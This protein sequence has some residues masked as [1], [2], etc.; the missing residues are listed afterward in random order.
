MSIGGH[1][2]SAMAAPGRLWILDPP[3]GERPVERIALGGDYLPALLAGADDAGRCAAMAA[4]LAPAVEGAGWMMADEHPEIHVEAPDPLR[5]AA[6]TLHLTVA[7]VDAL[8][9][10]VVAGG[11]TLDRGPEEG[12]VGR[13]AVFRDPFGHRWFLN[14]SSDS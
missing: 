4:R 7:D 8:V 3:A 1:T 12:P 9:V 14:Q 6:V 5:G 10:R 2:L 11:A 13:I